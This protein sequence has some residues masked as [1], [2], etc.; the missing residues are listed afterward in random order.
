MFRD[1]SFA[2]PN[3]ERQVLKNI[4]LT[5]EAGK[6]YA[7]VGSNGAGKSTLIH[8]L[9]TLYE[10][11]SGDIRLDDRELRTLDSE[12]V[13]GI[14][15]VAAQKSEPFALTVA[16]FLALGRRTPVADAEIDALPPA[17]QIRELIEQLEQGGETPLGRLAQEGR[18]LSGGQWQRLAIARALLR[19][20][21][22]FIFDEPTA[23]LDPNAE[24]EIYRALLKHMKQGIGILITHRLGAIAEVDHIVLLHEGKVEAVG[25]HEELMRISPRYAEMYEVQRSWYE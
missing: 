2:Y 24:R 11:Y 19:D 17:L 23:P 1:V 18:D 4:D 3:G 25:T 13:R 21:E 14:L 16:E 8:L 12:A 9:T 15:A 10:H 22:V 6:V 20:A 7:L 5:F